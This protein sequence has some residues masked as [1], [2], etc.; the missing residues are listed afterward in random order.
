MTSLP[1]QPPTDSAST[2]A[3]LRD[4]LWRR[5]PLALAAVVVTPLLAVGATAMLPKTY[6]STAKVMVQEGK[7]VNPLLGELMV[8]WSVKNRIDLMQNVLSSHSTLEQVLR[9]LDQLQ[10]GDSPAKVEAAVRRF[11]GEIEMFGMAGGI[12]QMKVTRSSPELTYRTLQVLVDTFITEMLRPQKEAI[13]ES[14]E[15]L[16]AQL[17]RL[18]QELDAEEEKL[19]AFKGENAGEL[20]EVFKNNLE[21]QLGLQKQLLEARVGLRAAERQKRLYEERLRSQSPALRQLEAKLQEATLRLHDLGATLTG[22]HPQVVAQ[23]ELITRLTREREEAAAVGTDLDLARLEALAAAHRP[24]ERRAAG[25]PD[26]ADALMADIV[27]Y[28]SVLSEIEGA[29]G[30]E[31]ML[32]QRLDEV[33]AAVRGF[34]QNERVLNAL[35]RERDTKA[36]VYRDLLAKY[37]DA[38]VTRELALFDE[39]GQVWIIEPPT[40]PVAPTQPALAVVGAGGL[41]GGLV[42]GVVLAALA[43][44]LSGTVRRERVQALAGTTVLG[45]LRPRSAA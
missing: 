21:V 6:K 7:Q 8:Q 9:R 24:D 28:K 17:E 14:T 13:T 29:V 36:K 15:F 10:P 40:R 32:R 42:L 31:G 34:A 43:E 20:P 33:D 16:K 4:A 2:L 39:K 44:F 37:Q 30:R 19:A 35:L 41:A 26:V 1:T 18:R 22:Q 5:W 45:S 25:V 27:S 38:L 23:R 11:R 3:L 12:V